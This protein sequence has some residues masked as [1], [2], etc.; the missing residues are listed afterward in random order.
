LIPATGSGRVGVIGSF[1]G[2]VPSLTM[3]FGR[4]ACVLFA[5]ARLVA[6]RRMQAV[7]NRVGTPGRR[8][9]MLLVMGCHAAKF[10]PGIATGMGSPW[11]RSARFVLPMGTVP[12]VRGGGF[13]AR[14]PAVSRFARSPPPSPG[15]ALA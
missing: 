2:S 1:G 14:A 10:A 11:L 7:G 6:R 8:V 3:R 4:Y 13:G 5:G 9:P 12:G 15:R